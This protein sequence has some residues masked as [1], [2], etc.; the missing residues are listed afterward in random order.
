MS[1]P[2]F[3]L[4]RIS[5]IEV[6]A[7]IGVHDAEQTARQRL[8]VSVT[9]MAAPA[10]PGDNLAGVLDYDFVREG[11]LKRVAAK[12]YNLQEALCADILEFCILR[13]GV[14]GAVVQTDKPDVYPGVSGVACRM[15]RM[16]PGLADFPWWTL[17]V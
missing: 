13:R 6:S 3:Y 5:G 8:L 14:L 16:G 11:V 17:P 2:S 12:H 10:T 15:A 9:L 7:S 1:H 4:I